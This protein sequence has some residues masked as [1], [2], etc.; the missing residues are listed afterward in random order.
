[1]Q[2]FSQGCLPK[3]WQTVLVA[4]GFSSNKLSSLPDWALNFAILE[5]SDITEK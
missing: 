2:C 1:V 4:Y 3:P 5:R